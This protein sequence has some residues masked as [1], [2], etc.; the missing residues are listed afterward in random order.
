MTA[1]ESKIGQI[2]LVELQAPNALARL[3]SELLLLM[4]P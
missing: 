2:K 4:C 3:D 1:P